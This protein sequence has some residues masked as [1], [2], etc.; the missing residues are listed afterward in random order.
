VKPFETPLAS[1]VMKLTELLTG[2]CAT[3]DEALK[4]LGHVTVA[5]LRRIIEMRHLK[6]PADEQLVAKQLR[7]SIIRRKVSP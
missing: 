5:L 1:K 4:A 6:P 2:L 3:P 7:I